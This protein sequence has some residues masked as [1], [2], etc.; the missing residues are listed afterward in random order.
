LETFF[1]KVVQLSEDDLVALTQTPTWLA[2]VA[3]APTV[4]RECRAFSAQ[5]FDPE[6][7]ARI[8]VPVLLLVGKDSPVEIQADPDV[9][10]AALPDARIGVL[11][12]QEH[13]AHLTD[14]EAFAAQVLEFLRE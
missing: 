8:A 6:Q 7:G 12:G 5:A 10:A 2:R 3:A 11:R 4:P 1:R 14:P 13:M 9:V